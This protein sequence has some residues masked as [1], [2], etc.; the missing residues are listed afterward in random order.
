MDFTPALCAPT[1]ICRQRAAAMM[2]EVIAGAAHEMHASRVGRLQTAALHRPHGVQAPT[3]HA[4]WIDT[5]SACPSHGHCSRRDKET[6]RRPFAY[7]WWPRRMPLSLL[8]SRHARHRRHEPWRQAAPRYTPEDSDYLYPAIDMPNR[9]VICH[10]KYPS[11]RIFSTARIGTAMSASF[12]RHTT[13]HEVPESRHH[14]FGRDTFNRPT[15]AV[16]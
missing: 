13:A 8:A 2:R 10:Q 6:F 16:P 4:R 12:I 5:G 14:R 1:F 11:H 3:M 7:A 15:T 9:P